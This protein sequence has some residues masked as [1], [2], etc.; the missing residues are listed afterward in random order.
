MTLAPLLARRLGRAALAAALVP[1]ALAAQGSLGTQGYGYPT[2]H[3]S[4]RALVL[5]SAFEGA[6]I[7][8]IRFF[9][10]EAPA[11]LRPRLRLS[12]I[13]RTEFGLP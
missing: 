3:L 13:P 1:A 12:Y 7:G 5:R 4:T 2:G 6:E 10:R 8:E 9:S 11:A